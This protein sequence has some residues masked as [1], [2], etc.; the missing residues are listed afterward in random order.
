MTKSK[1]KVFPLGGE[2]QWCVKCHQTR[3]VSFRS[4]PLTEIPFRQFYCYTCGTALEEHTN[5]GVPTESERIR[6]ELLKLELEEA[7]RKVAHLIRMINE[8]P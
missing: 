8:L 1:H 4:T 6:K 7:E 2:G 5:C 3:Y